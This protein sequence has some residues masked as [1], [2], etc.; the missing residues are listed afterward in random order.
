MPHISLGGE[1]A[2]TDSL[3]KIAQWA[4]G[5]VEPGQTK[6]TIS[7]EALPVQLHGAPAASGEE[8]VTN[9][10]IGADLLRVPAGTGF[11][12]HTHPGHH[13]LIVVGGIGTITYG[14]RVYETKAGQTY[15]IDG[16]VPHAVGAITDHVILAI[17]SPHKA[18]DAEDR[19][20]PVPYEEVL[21]PEGDLTCTICDK[22]ALAP[23]RL[24]EVDCPHCPCRECV[25]GESSP[26]SE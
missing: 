5:A 8:M 25:G 2:A 11:E 23:G 16:E 3:L 1:G 9:G 12:P 20:A 4:E 10:M 17:G 13:V 6:L 14:G 24:H 21:A 15:L 7:H 22:V 26:R 19:M 18:I